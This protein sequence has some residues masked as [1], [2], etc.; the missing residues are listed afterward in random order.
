LD[1]LAGHEGVD[2]LIR[3]VDARTTA[4]PEAARQVVRLC[5]EL[6]LVRIAAARLRSRTQW[7]VTHLAERLSDE[8]RRLADLKLG[9]LDV[10][11]TF[12]M[13][14]RE[15]SLEQATLFRRLGV[16]PSPEFD[17]R[18]AV[19]L[20]TGAV[21]SEKIEPLLE[22][23]A[24]APLL[25]G[26][27]RPRRRPAPAPGA[28]LAGQRHSGTPAGAGAGRRDGEGRGHVSETGRPR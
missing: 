4:E 3:L 12:D 1:A 23:L 2:L 28:G 19:F 24:G 13:S 6:P 22:E 27:A 18:L 16:V 20:A 21:T 11:A 25:E 15:L 8:R 26:I 7:S 10:R 5:G 17:A 9:D 14:Y